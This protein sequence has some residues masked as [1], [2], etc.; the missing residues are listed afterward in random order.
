MSIATRF[1]VGDHIVPT[2]A[3][4]PIAEIIEIY[5]EGVAAVR[6]PSGAIRALTRDQLEDYRKVIPDRTEDLALFAL[7]DAYGKSPAD[8][9]EGLMIMFI[10]TSSKTRDQIMRMIRERMSAKAT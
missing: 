1:K 3:P 8:L 5:P 9:F 10:I 7:A 6:W 2:V 4:P